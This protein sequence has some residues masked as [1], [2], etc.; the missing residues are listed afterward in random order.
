MTR[1][2]VHIEWR[3]VAEPETDE[4]AADRRWASLVGPLVERIAALGGRVIGW[5]QRGLIADFAWDGLYDAIDFV[6]DV[7][8]APQLASAMSLGVPLVAQDLGRVALVIGPAVRSAAQLVKAAEAGEV[9]LD[10]TLVA[11]AGGRLGISGDWVPRVGRPSVQASILDPKMPLL[12]AGTGA[13]PAASMAPEQ[14]PSERAPES[15][16]D[17]QVER[18]TKS[19]GALRGAGSSVFPPELVSTL[20]KRDAASLKQLADA[21]R[22]H[23]TDAAE[24]LD[25]IAQL[26]DGHSGEALRRLRLKKEQ[27]LAEGPRSRCRS[28]LALAVALASA[29]RPYE[30]ALQGLDGLARA[31]QAQDPRGEQACARLLSQIA[32]AMGDAPA[33]SAWASLAP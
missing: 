26:A 22:G 9:L 13:R 24:R 25:A 4:E 33:A 12:E 8:L 10:P 18:L 2:V 27:S 19:A 11:A 14:S 7:P 21:V 3:P 31:R 20:R 6:V 17:A 16:V 15:V 23:A 30:A 1:I 5:T 29:G 32:E 28:A